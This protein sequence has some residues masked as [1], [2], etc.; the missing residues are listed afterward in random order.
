MI[1]YNPQN[2]KS[3]I[4]TKILFTLLIHHAPLVYGEQ[5]L[6]MQNIFIV[7]QEAKNEK[8]KCF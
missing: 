7:I 4:F 5:C 2:S 3:H 1:M 6:L 8:H